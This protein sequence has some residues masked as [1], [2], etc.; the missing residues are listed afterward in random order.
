MAGGRLP[1]GLAAVAVGA[2]VVLR[3]MQ[4]ADKGSK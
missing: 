3:A 1:K 2:G 4:Q